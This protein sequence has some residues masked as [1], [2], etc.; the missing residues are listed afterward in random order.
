MSDAARDVN[1]FDALDG[2][3]PDGPVLR[4]A[5]APWSEKFWRTFEAE[6]SRTFVPL[7]GGVGAVQGAGTS[8]YEKQRILDRYDSLP[9]WD[10][11]LTDASAYLG[12][13]LLAQATALENYI[14]LTAGA[15]L[16][17]GLGIRT[18][19]VG[20]RVFAG[21]VDA[22]VANAAIDAAVQ[23]MEVKAGQR[24]AFDPAEF[25]ASVG[26]GAAIGG[27]GGGIGA[28]IG[29]RAPEAAPTV[30]RETQ[31]P[32]PQGPAAPPAGAVDAPPQTAGAAAGRTV[33]PRVAAAEPQGPPAA[34]DPLP[35][36]ARPALPEPP[37]I[38]ERLDTLARQRRGLGPRPVEPRAPD[39]MTPQRIPEPPP[40]AGEQVA[41]PRA[42][43]RNPI[44][45]EG[46]PGEAMNRRELFS[47]APPGNRAGAIA[48]AADGTPGPQAAAAF[49][50]LKDIS[51]RLARALEAPAVRMG[52]VSARVQGKAAAGQ[53][54]ATT[55]VVRLAK[56]D[57]FDVLAHELGHHLEVR[58]GKP[59]RDLMKAHAA[60]LEPLAYAGHRKGDTLKEGFAEYAR[61]MI[62][63]PAAAA[64]AAPGFDAAFRKLLAA[65]DPDTL[66][67]IADAAAAWR[68]W[69]EQPSVDAV[70]STIVSGKEPRLAPQL[71]K[72]LEAAGFLGT[73]AERL[74]RAY[75]R[76]FD[77]LHPL[78]RAVRGLLKVAAAN[79]GQ[80]LDLKVA[81][82]PYKL[83][84]MSR[85]AYAA[86]HM[87][88]MYGVH[89]YRGTR[90]LSASLR[91]ALVVAFGKP[92]VLS[93][94]DD[95]LATRFGAYLWS[96]RAL[97]EWDRFDAGLIPNPP[98][99]LTRGDHARNV[100]DSEA[101]FPQ[102]AEA[103][104]MIYDWNR[105]LWTKKRDAGLITFEQWEEGLKIRDYVPG[106][107]AFDQEGD[108]AGATRGRSG[109][110]KSG[111]TRRFRGSRRDVINP[112]ESLIADAYETAAAIARNDVLK[113]L[114]RL[115]RQAGPGA[116]RFAEPIPA[117]R[118][119]AID[120][121]PLDA[122]ERAARQ[123][124]MAKPDIV[125][126]RDSLE[127]AIGDDRVALFRP[128]VITGNGEPIVF[129]R[130]G[131]EL[132]ALRLADGE[133]GQQMYAVLTGMTQREK[134][135]FIDLLAAPA[136]ALRTGV[137]ASPEFILANAIRDQATAMI[138][139]GKP[140]TRLAS[141]ARGAADELAQTDMA[142]LYNLGQGIMGGANVAD[143]SD[144]RVRH[145]LQALRRK[146]WLA[147]RASAR[148][149]LEATE[150]SETAMR[151]GLF[152]T[153]LDEAKA[154][155]LSEHEALLEAAYRARDHLDF[156]RRG[157]AMTGLAR[158]IPFLNVSLQGLD[159]TARH[160]IAPFFDAAAS[161]AERAAAAMTWARLGAAT[162][163]SIG[164]HALMT[165]HDEYL[166]LSPQ[167]RASHWA[168]RFG[169]KWLMV[170]K[171]F[172]L[173]AVINLGEAAWDALVRQDPRWAEHY[174]QSLMEVT[175]PPSLMEG[176]PAI[177]TSFELA[178]GVKLR[179]GE[180]IVPE[181]MEGLA[182][183]LQFTAKTSELARL[184]GR[185]ANVPPVVAD[186]VIVSVTGSIGRN[187][188]A[189]YDYALSDKPAQGWDDF[190][191]TRRFIKDG[192][193]GASST[194]AFW[195]MVSTRT[196]TLEG[197]RRTWQKMMDAGDMA[198]AADWLAGQDAITR[199][200]VAAGPLPAEVRR[201]HPF[202]RARAAV[203]A[204]NALR[205]EMMDDTV[206][207]A[208]GEVKVSRVDRG[209]ADDILEDL[210]QVEAR[211]A[212]VLMRV[213]GW[214][215]REPIDTSTYHR[216]LAA[217]SP[218]LGRALADR[219]AG[220]KVLPFGRVEDLWPELERRLLAG[221]SDI[222]VG[223]LALKAR[224]AGFELD[225]KPI[226][227]KPRAGVPAGLTGSP[228]P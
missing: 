82:N 136:V 39:D 165:E 193:R 183:H 59:V 118:I 151:L 149:L 194:R 17:A 214:A 123:A 170:P 111:F 142:R 197:A 58:H 9:Q 67:A 132:R 180:P 207:T 40:A 134:N 6:R 12:G 174:R 179:D 166:D 83:A 168:I 155:G 105:A 14:P 161:P 217:I 80:R 202:E 61:L 116:G 204:I 3:E 96:R 175:L 113:Y 133:F 109:D 191:I 88:I 68:A 187:L 95:E 22:G 153:F 139:Y 198:R 119:A 190:A 203:T 29:R 79:T 145:D 77:N 18:A 210:A 86:G 8:V 146:G 91:D 129:W 192:S 156:N 137:T 222:P 120:V 143:L 94:W 65:G 114:D 62:T 33:E 157:S 43:E 147:S 98:D 16:L 47:A 182:P 148:G 52:R 195:D 90:P 173:A 171:P 76:Y 152:R 41:P 125:T 44:M 28:M 164:V 101:R 219:Y 78:N 87:D 150:L 225:G 57:D 23:Q 124:G 70:A 64:R 176:N 169:G 24:E 7:T 99:K 127:A 37:A 228:P 26:L 36:A 167:T 81:A 213:P 31:G 135:V 56:P 48:R 200:W 106:L 121:D 104:A 221:G 209:A 126:L 2:A 162:V 97:G 160:M 30:S 224:A 42:A 201:L 93:R 112:V 185:A 216:E 154:R 46:L 131:G 199:A 144:L 71:R 211:N 206:T 122:V 218:D 100:A 51:E 45:D 50:R 10:G 205:R 66:T 140:L 158:L 110:A 21:A 226:K 138:Y 11:T 1:P 38:G 63:N 223:D 212:L 184:I 159:K 55:G 84:R 128:A 108:A 177:A 107:R 186:H 19:S 141:T 25:A 27:A 196:G 188:L 13:M 74:H 73:I 69:N 15:N 115:A 5:P 49:T 130:D 72:D 89:G 117:H 220:G 189:L 102:F 60:E 92:N 75:G 103:A 208:A 53:Y 20:A 163:F 54:S 85:G 34:A 4:A 32:E 178:T 35:G 172:E 227:R 181:G 215:D